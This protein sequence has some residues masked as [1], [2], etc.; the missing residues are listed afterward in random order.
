MEEQHL[1]DKAQVARR[2]L[3]DLYFLKRHQMI[4]R[5]EKVRPVAFFIYRLSLE[6]RVEGCLQLILAGTQF[7]YPSG[8]DL[9]G[10][11]YTEMVYVST[12]N[13]PSQ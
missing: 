12:D 2:Q 10:W 11:L 5:H 3:K 6:L 9:G 4:T 8:V 1:K 13:H 7:I